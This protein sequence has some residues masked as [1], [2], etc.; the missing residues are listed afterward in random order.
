[1]KYY[2]ENSHCTPVLGGLMLDAMF[3]GATTFGIKL[4]QANI[5]AHLARVLEDRAAYAR[6]NAADIAWVSR[7]LSEGTAGGK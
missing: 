1:M 7:I 2:F 5:K 3:E 6:T 4:D